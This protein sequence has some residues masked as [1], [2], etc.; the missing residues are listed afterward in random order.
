MVDV[1]VVGAHPDD[2]EMGFGGSVAKLVGLGYE[3]AMLDLTNGEPTPFG[4]PET[5][6]AEASKAAGVLGVKTRITLDIPN[7]EMTDSVENRHK[8]A[9]VYR[10]LRPERLFLQWDVDAHPDHVEGA[11]LSEKARFDAKLTKAQIK[12]DPWYPS[13]VFHYQASHLRLHL[14]PSF[15]LDVSDTFEKKLECVRVYQSQFRA[16]GRE[17]VAMEKLRNMAAW[18]G[19]LIGVKYGEPVMMKEEVG[20]RD[21]RDILV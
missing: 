10:E 15:I 21:I 2:I 17:D 3:V 8:V 16:A 1:L 19:Q 13:K 5:R 18:H 4:N 12:G 11:A 20:M 9:E 7:R 14:K 6:A